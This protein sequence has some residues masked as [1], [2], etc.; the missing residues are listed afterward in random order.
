LVYHL[1]IAD[2]ANVNRFSRILSR[3]KGN[4]AN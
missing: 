1:P 4:G 2:E 3:E